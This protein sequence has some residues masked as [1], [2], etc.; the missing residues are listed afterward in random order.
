MVID[1]QELDKENMN[2]NRLDS[3]ASSASEPVSI[4]ESEV[5]EEANQSTISIKKNASAMT[6]EIYAKESSI[7][8]NPFH[9]EMQDYFKWVLNDLHN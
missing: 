9:K 4:N 8:I 6:E 2:I 7:G 5:S 3:C 1:D